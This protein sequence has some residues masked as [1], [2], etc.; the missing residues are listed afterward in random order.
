MVEKKD[1]RLGSNVRDDLREYCDENDLTYSE[2]LLTLLPEDGEGAQLDRG[3]GV[4]ISIRK[5]AYDQI[6]AL[7]GPGVDYGDVVAHFL[8]RESEEQ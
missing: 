5:S 3:S 4:V 6:D 7:A 1:I 2:A 8:Y